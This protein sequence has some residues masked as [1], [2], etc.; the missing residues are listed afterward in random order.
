M[1]KTL[2]SWFYY[3]VIPKFVVV[4][5]QNTH[6]NVVIFMPAN[7]LSLIQPLIRA[8]NARETTMMDY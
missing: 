3:W 4:K 8:Y 7:M 5:T 6:P 1:V 2:P